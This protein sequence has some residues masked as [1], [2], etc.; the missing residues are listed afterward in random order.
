MAT[1][2]RSGFFLLLLLSGCGWDS[3][4]QGDF[5]STMRNSRGGLMAAFAVF[6][7]VQLLS[8]FES[9]L[10]FVYTCFMEVYLQ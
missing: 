6:A 7:A 10:C 9:W 3:E 4:H 1:L 5:G 2:I 8:T